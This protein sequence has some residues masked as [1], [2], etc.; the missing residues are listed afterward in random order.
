ME[1]HTTLRPE[2]A[3]GGGSTGPEVFEKLIQG[4]QELDEM[5]LKL[6]DYSPNG[7]VAKTEDK[8][9]NKFHTYFD[10]VFFRS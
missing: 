5:G 2:S 8:R 6:V 9:E 3:P 7:C 10:V 1:F 4:V